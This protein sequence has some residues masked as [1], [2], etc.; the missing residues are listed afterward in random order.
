MVYKGAEESGM[1]VSYTGVVRID[2]SFQHS[3][4]NVRSVCKS[5]W[6]FEAK[7]RGFQLLSSSR[8]HFRI[9]LLTVPK[10]QRKGLRKANRFVHVLA[11]FSLKV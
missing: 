11:L 2:W 1:S 7:V 9:R 4:R 6:V 10:V 8:T 3:A 5:S